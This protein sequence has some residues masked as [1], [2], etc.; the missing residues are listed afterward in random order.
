MRGSAEGSRES[1]DKRDTQIRKQSV[2]FESEENGGKAEPVIKKING[3]SGVRS[4][5]GPGCRS[6]IQR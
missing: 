6:C 1:S 4:D 5:L 2:A 3:D